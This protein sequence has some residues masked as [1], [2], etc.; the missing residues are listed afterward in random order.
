MVRL[1]SAIELP[2]PTRSEL[3]GRLRELRAGQPELDTGLTWTPPHR[4]HITLGFYGDREHADRRATWF[5]RQAIGL[6][7]ARLRLRGAGRFP[8]VLW[9]GVSPVSAQD[10]SALRAMAG[11]LNADANA[12]VLDF[13]AHVTVARWRRGSGGGERGMLAAGSLAD[14]AGAPWTAGEVVLFRSDQGT[15]EQ[16]RSGPVY[17][18]L[19]RVTLASKQG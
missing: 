17:T 3:A 7:A 9:V 10:A 16:G 5:R 1:F 12:G 18:P 11:A 13:T 2:E 19:D 6:A 8:G 15:P 4:W 14:F